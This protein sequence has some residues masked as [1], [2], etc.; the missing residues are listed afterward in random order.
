[1]RFED[2][3]NSF[4]P[5]IVFLLAVLY[6]LYS[7]L[8]ITRAIALQNDVI[9]SFMKSLSEKDILFAIFE[10]LKIVFVQAALPLLP[11]LFLISFGFLL[12]FALKESMNSK[13][14]IGLQILFLA[15][16]LAIANFSLVIFF[17]CIGILM[18]SISL[19]RFFEP[20][21][22]NFSTG[23]SLTSKGLNWINI[24]IATGLFL[25]MY[26]NFQSYQQTLL[27]S[28]MDLIKSFVPDA[29]Q[30]Q[31]LQIELVNK[32]IDD[33]KL[34][35]TQKCQQNET[36]AREQCK[37]AYDAVLADIEN[38]KKNV[39]EQVSTQ[40]VSDEQLQ[41][42]IMKSFPIIE[43][44]VKAAPLFLALAFFALLEV[45]KPF[46][47]IAFGAIYSIIRKFI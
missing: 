9:V 47:S 28:N 22:T 2:I 5:N 45:L 42:Y 25:S 14:F 41:V 36:L 15:I 44:T 6:L 29:D 39:T 17:V 10:T 11:F 30:V 40:K 35:I 13:V 21:K 8:S 19:L 38:Y 4:V 16:A 46:I 20:E 12:L 26:A 32:T 43:Q 27:Q 7:G 18:A 24:L 33:I 23:N 31:K 3:R 37:A 34:S 1:M